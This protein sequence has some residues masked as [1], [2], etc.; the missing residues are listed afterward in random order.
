[1]VERL[2]DRSLM[3]AISSGFQARDKVPPT[4]AKAIR[5]LPSFAVQAAAVADDSYE[6]NDTQQ[7]AYNLGGLSSGSKLISGLA[8]AD[9]ADWYKFSVGKKLGA[10][11][12]ASI[13]FQ[14]AQGDLDLVLYK[15]SGARLKF[16][17]TVANSESVSLNG[18]AAGTYF[19]RVYGYLGATNPAYSLSIN[20]GVS[21]GGTSGG[22]SGGSSGGGSSGGS[23][24]TTD[25]AF[26]NNDSRE[27]AYNLGQLSVPSTFSSLVMA[28]GND[29]YRF[30][31]SSK[32][33]AGNV[34]SLSS[35]TT[36]GNLNLELYNSAGTRL[37]G[38]SSLTNTEEISLLGRAGGTYYVR[39]FGLNNARTSNYQLVI[40]PGTPE[41]LPPAPPPPP[42]PPPGGGGGTTSTFDIVIR[43]P[44]MSPALLAVFDQAATKWESVITGDLP[45]INFQGL[46]VDD[47]LIDAS[48]VPIDGVNGILGQ[49]GPRAIRP[50]GSRLPY[51]GIMQFDSADMAA[52]QA[53]GELLDVILHE[54]GHVLG[55]GSLWASKGLLLGA[56]TNNPI[57]V[58][59][60]ATAAYNAIFGTNANGVPVESTG[61]AGT[62]G[63]HWRETILSNELMT[64][65]IGPGNNLPL[66]RITVG[67]LADM[68]YTVDY[69]AADPYTMPLM[70]PVIGAGSA[71]GA[72][73]P[74]RSLTSGAPTS[75]ALPLA[76]QH[77]NLLSASSSASSSSADSSSQ[78]ANRLQKANVAATDALFA[79][80]EWELLL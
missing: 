67:S 59:A 36:Q 27:T 4:T 41:S 69:A 51:H 15:S 48:I 23:T 76:S 25:D 77:R 55:I 28:D 57:F 20:L 78:L 53:S 52:M 2:E 8:M 12:S 9:S 7:T 66:S 38:S 63:S 65:F 11:D 31:M 17:N 43:A 5:A 71:G 18:L 56:G 49:A 1:L 13:S 3:A 44:G 70:A 22:G 72:G 54:M 73:L 19:I 10:S 68:G 47:L 79:N 64:G 32:G 46:L 21:G 40:N 6:Q 16:S 29:W 30:A 35:P 62:A 74:L 42:P 60:Q 24:P 39:V 33:G 34:V 75:I 80:S 45:D 14:H 37:S 26:E 50:T 58:G 61:G